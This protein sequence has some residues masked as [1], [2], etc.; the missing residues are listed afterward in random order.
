MLD[1]NAVPII[2]FENVNKKYR[3]KGILTDINLDIKSKEIFGI[4][5]LSGSGKTTLLNLLIGFIKPDSGDVLFHSEHLLEYGQKDTFRSVFNKAKEVR[6]TFGFASQYPSFYEDLTVKE[7]LFYFGSLYNL[8]K[9]TLVTNTRAILHLMELYDAKDTK[10]ANLSGGMARRLDIGCALIHDPKVLILDEPTS[11]LDSQL[12]KHIWHLLRKIN[13]KGTTIILSSHHL[14]DLEFSCDKVAI[15][16]ESKIVNSGSPDELKNSYTKEVE[17]QVETVSGKYSDII[18]STKSLV[19]DDKT[20]I[21]DHKLKLYTSKVEDTLY[22]ILH[23]IVETDDV[24][25]DLMV[26][27]PSLVEV[28]ESLTKKTSKKNTK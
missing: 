21:I 24:L 3:G 5:G 13:A 20:L 18:N 7:N 28:F 2:R 6:K 22:K 25:I 12:R 9:D 26:S 11:D 23:K 14:E 17:I 19:T 10:A 4:I 16:H 27:K 1:E 15:I 8:P